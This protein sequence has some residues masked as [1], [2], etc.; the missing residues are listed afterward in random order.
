M[1]RKMLCAAGIVFFLIGLCIAQEQYFPKEKRFKEIVKILSDNKMQGRLAYT[2]S[3][4]DAA[5]WIRDQLKTIGVK[6]L[7]SNNNDWFQKIYPLREVI[8]AEQS[9][10]FQGSNLEYKKDFNSLIKMGT[11]RASGE[12]VFVG[13]GISAPKE[14][15]DD[16][17]GIDVRG[18]IVLMLRHEPRENSYDLSK[19]KG[20]IVT[21]HSQ[22]QM[23]IKEA[24]ERGA[25][26][27]LIANLPGV[28]G[29]KTPLD[30][31][32]SVLT[33][34][35]LVANFPYDVS[36]GYT[37]I[38]TANIPVCSVSDELANELTGKNLFEIS[39]EI[40]RDVRPRSFATGNT[41]EFSVTTKLKLLET[42]NVLGYIPRTVNDGSEEFVVISA[43][44]DHLG[45][46]KKMI[47]NGADDNASGV[48]A[49]L[50]IAEAIV[51][52]PTP[53]ERSIIVALFTAEEEGL[54]GSA[55]FVD[56]DLQRMKSVVANLNFDMVGRNDPRN[57]FINAVPPNFSME[58]NSIVDILKQEN[59]DLGMPF[60]IRSDDGSW[61]R[62]DSLWFHLSGIPT[63][64]F[65]TGEHDDYHTP[66]DTA[67]KVDYSKL[68]RV[69]FLGY[70][71]VE[72]LVQ[73]RIPIFFMC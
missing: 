66:Y 58:C 23:K 21:V 32:D 37:A 3:A 4:D 10:V 27:I 6:T 7:P 68:R 69:S 1:L 5:V 41:L 64:H 59:L 70:R 38:E 57:L 53:R 24:I 30:F 25:V 16:Y 14:D 72:R 35:R 13:Y 51:K 19:F 28:D 29:I 26:G 60:K 18:K 63:L 9:M 2:K 12:V 34:V 36:Y 20:V 54:W 62:T 67:D 65:F 46:I 39:K 47:W 8:P 40:D 43:H 71:V 55:Y 45:A 11:G 48:A 31:D 15:Y 22:L 33:M 50:G 52:N 44:Y 61:G 49:V 73:Y 42:H 17:Q 56:S